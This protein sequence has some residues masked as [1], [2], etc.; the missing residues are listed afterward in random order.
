M[1]DSR[2]QVLGTASFLR[3][4]GIPVPPP[5]D[6]ELQESGHTLVWLGEETTLLAVFVIGDEVRPG[7]QELVAHLKRQGKQV[8]LLT[9]DHERVAER[10]GHAVGIDNVAANLSPQDKLLRV[11]QLAAGGAVVAMVGD[12]VNDAAALAGAHVSIAMGHGAQL[13]AASADLLLLSDQLSHLDEGIAV[14]R[15]T[16][17][18]I[19]QN[20]TWAVAYNLLALPF[21]AMGFIAPWMAALGMS[22][23]SLLV[24]GNALRLGD[25]S[26]RATLQAR[27]VSA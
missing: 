12:G 8:L 15:R 11:Q 10:V 19:R 17:A 6:S 14:A 22:A 21:A 1:V 3:E 13:A 16:L 7:A 26:A 18:I 5:L 27:P 25:R 9:G 24:V 2:T 4:A 20:L 23:S